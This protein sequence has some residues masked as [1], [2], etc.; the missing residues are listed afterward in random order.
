MQLAVNF[1]CGVGDPAEYI[2]YL[3]IK[4]D[5]TPL[6]EASVEAK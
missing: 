4:G 6:V 5:A 1:P 2:N 3:R